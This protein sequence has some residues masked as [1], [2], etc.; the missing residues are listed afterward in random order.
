MEAECHNNS[1]GEPEH[2]GS[3]A[4]RRRGRGQR[5]GAFMRRLRFR[6]QSDVSRRRA[7]L[8]LMRIFR[9]QQKMLM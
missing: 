5:A 6:L 8:D 3:G 9:R 2:D 1:G 7:R 4:E